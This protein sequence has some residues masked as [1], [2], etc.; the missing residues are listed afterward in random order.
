MVPIDMQG[1]SVEYDGLE[2]MLEKLGPKGAAEV[3]VNGRNLFEQ[4]YAIS[5]RTVLTA[6]ICSQSGNIQ[7]CTT[8]LAGLIVT[9]G[10]FSADAKV[11]ELHATILDRMGWPGARFMSDDGAVVKK[12][13]NLKQH[14]RL[15]VEPEYPDAPQPMTVKELRDLLAEDILVDTLFE[16]E[17]EESIEESE[18]SGGED[19]EEE[20]DEPPAKKAKID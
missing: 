3:F 19:T 20:D 16:G 11:L 17:E 1:A 9:E 13:D 10:S 12:T 5:A 14:C 18:A 4:K 6:N 8:S 7:V 15:T 2:D